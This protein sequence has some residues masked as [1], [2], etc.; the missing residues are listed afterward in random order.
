[1]K[2]IC[3]LLLTSF[4]F[5]SCQKKQEK[6]IS[7]EWNYVYLSNVS[8]TTQTWDFSNDKNLY[9]KITT[10]TTIIDTANWKIDTKVFE[11]PLLII[12]NFKDSLNNGIYEVLTLN[13]KY[14]VAQR[15]SFLNG[16]TGGA[17]NRIEFYK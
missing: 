8:N 2:N 13:K 1:M 10:D 14:L 9:R 4:I 17:F 5:I 11:R 12:S 7:G 16:T 3:I 15:I 6:K